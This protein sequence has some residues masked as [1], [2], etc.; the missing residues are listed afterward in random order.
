MLGVRH[1]PWSGRAWPPRNRTVRVLL[2]CLLVGFG[3]GVA[4]AELSEDLSRTYRELRLRFFPAIALTPAAK[5]YRAEH[6]TYLRVATKFLKEVPEDEPLHLASV[7][8]LR[9]R[10]LEHCRTYELAR[11]DLDQA[12]AILAEQKMSRD[13]EPPMRIPG[14][15]PVNAVRFYRAFTFADQGDAAIVAQLEAIKDGAGIPRGEATEKRITA[16]IARLETMRQYAEAIR[17]Y[18]V[19]QRF[20]LWDDEGFEPERMIGLL[21]ARAEREGVV[22]PEQVVHPGKAEQNAAP[23]DPEPP[24]TP[25]KPSD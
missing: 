10:L 23:G 8:V 3:A 19:V 14:L 2:V 12:L 13:G 16:L 17:T 4:R 22:L 9:G 11:K 24:A 21:K 7:L 18:R 1:N 6:L 20:D 25:P 5:A 15:P